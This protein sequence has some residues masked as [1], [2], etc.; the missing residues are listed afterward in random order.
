MNFLPSILDTPQS[1]AE[2]EITKIRERL[3]MVLLYGTMILGPII[4]FINIRDKAWQTIVFYTVVYVWVLMIT[5]HRRI[6]YHIRAGSVIVALYLLGTTISITH[7]IVGDGRI[8]MLGFTLL[9]SVFFNPQTGILSALLGT[10]TLIGIGWIVDQEIIS[11]E[12]LFQAPMSSWYRT[13]ASFL[14]MSLLTSAAI[15][16]L[17]G[18]LAERL[19]RERDISNELEQDRQ[20]LRKK[21]TDLEQRQMQLQTTAEISKAITSELDPTTIFQLTVNLLQERLNLYYTG[22]FI[23][24][25]E[26]QYAVLKAGSGEEGEAMLAEGY[27]VPANENSIVGWAIVNNEA[28]TSQDIEQDLFRSPHLPLT[29]SELAIPIASRGRVWGA[30]SI[31]SVNAQGFDESNIAILKTITDN[32]ASAFE[33]AQLYQQSQDNLEEISSL[34]RQYLQQ[35]WETVTNDKDE[36]KHVFVNEAATSPED[37]TSTIKAPLI[38]R[39]QQIGNLVIE[40]ANTNLTREEK[41]ILDSLTN[42]A[43]LAL[44]NARLLEVTQQRAQRDRIVSEIAGKVQRATR[45]DEALKTTLQE[46]GQTLK[47]SEGTIYLEINE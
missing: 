36:L 29:R 44:E 24:D 28:H 33:N 3:L 1:Q 14:L 37:E 26:K 15:S 45:V 6:K 35:A 43:A 20:E 27:Q 9:T 12:A 42:Q 40:T 30:V 7:G 11:S 10:G 46:L 38:L 19:E 23:L 21:T 39:G 47:A 41:N 18:T 31:Q 32:L 5:F 25:K 22:I 2:N 8:W 17:L 4:Y 16:Y 34:H 13:S